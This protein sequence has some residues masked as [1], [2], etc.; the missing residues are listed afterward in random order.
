MAGA[1]CIALCP[2]CTTYEFMWDAGPF[3]YRCT[4]C[5]GLVEKKL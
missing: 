3:F 2:N 1:V 5:Y 4:E